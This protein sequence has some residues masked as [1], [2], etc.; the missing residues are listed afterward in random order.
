MCKL[1][2]GLMHIHIT[3]HRI[4]PYLVMIALSF[5]TGIGG[6]YLLNVRRGIGRQTA[7]C[8]ALLSP[9][10]SIVPAMLQSY[11]ETG[12]IGLSS[13]GGLAGMY[14][15]V[16]TVAPAA[17]RPGYGRIMTQNVTL[18]LPL[19]YAVSKLGCFLAGCCR[20][21]PYSGLLAVHY[22]G[23]T[24]ADAFPV[25]LAESAVFTL[26]FLLGMLGLRRGYRHTPELV[27]FCA[28]AAKFLL[29][30]LR[31]AHIGH[32]LTVNQVLC[33]ILIAA[34]ILCIG[35]RTRRARRSRFPLP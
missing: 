5:L 19:M 28:A 7:R 20:G 25:Q 11:L 2:S 30:F 27:F 12:G 26:I 31:E 22:T 32:I 24:T 9:V 29:D 8:L 23:K 10:L 35:I 1:V 21:I 14:A 3:D 33:L 18:M 16:L 34:G 17:G 13:V 4:P 15:A 6:V